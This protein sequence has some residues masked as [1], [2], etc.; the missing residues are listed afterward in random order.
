MRK[1]FQFK[2]LTEWQ[3]E[4]F[5]NP[6]SHTS[7][8]AGKSE[9]EISAA[10]EFKGD[11]SLHN[12]EDLLLS[13]LSSCHMM[14]YFYVCKR[15]NI[16]ILSYKDNALGTL[17]LN[18]DSSGAFQKIQLRPQVVLRDTSQSELAHS[19][20]QQAHELCFIENSINFPVEIEPKFS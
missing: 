20:H 17:V 10:P 11:A 6:K 14:S 2:V 7:K 18:E 5:K 15:N 12:P 8:I 3:Q 13:A 19:L 16:D 4:V 1:L 9:L